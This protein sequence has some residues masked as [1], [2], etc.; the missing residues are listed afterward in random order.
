MPVVIV[1]VEARPCHTAAVVITTTVVKV[2][3]VLTMSGW[4]MCMSF[5]VSASEQ[6]MAMAEGVAK[7][8]SW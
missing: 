5:V 1:A 4:M 8:L 2:L 3:C 6:T 7:Q